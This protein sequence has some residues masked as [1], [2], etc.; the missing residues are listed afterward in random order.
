MKSA[1]DQ[2]R[3]TDSASVVRY[4]GAAG[5]RNMMDNSQYLQ[6]FVH[7]QLAIEKI[8][9]DKIVKVFSGEKAMKVRRAID[10]WGKEDRSRITKTYELIK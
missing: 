10:D 5:I 9:W 2:G 8:L 3:G 6:A 4:V 7:S 1:S